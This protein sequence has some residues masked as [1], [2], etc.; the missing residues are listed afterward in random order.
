MT[1]FSEL[2]PSFKDLLK[3]ITGHH[4]LTKSVVSIV[5]F[6]L[7]YLSFSKTKTKLKTEDIRN[8]IITT[9][10]GFLAITLFYVWHYF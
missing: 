4:W 3:S 5:F 9:L 7:I 1:I 8:T 10:V 2:S 6:F